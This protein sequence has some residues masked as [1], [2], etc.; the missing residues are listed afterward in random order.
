MRRRSEYL[1]NLP[2]FVRLTLSPPSRRPRLGLLALAQRVGDAGRLGAA[3][4]AVLDAPGGHDGLA[5]L[6][7]FLETFR[8]ARLKSPSFFWSSRHRPPA[9]RRARGWRR[10]ARRADERTWNEDPPQ[11]RCGAALSRTPGRPPAIAPD[12]S[13]L[14]VQCTPDHRFRHAIISIRGSA[15]DRVLPRRR[16][17]REGDLRARSERDGAGHAPTRWPSGSDVTPASA[18]GMVRKLDELGLVDARALPGR[19][20]HADGHAARARGAAPPPAARALPRRVARR[21]VGP[22]ARRG[23]GARARRSPRSSRR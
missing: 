12:G 3:A 6:T 21:A 1:R 10:P 13:Q 8:L 9:R 23:R 17:L 4:L 22:R 19:A 5:G 18:S 16:G 7:V 20:A 2:P 14:F 15:R 11:G